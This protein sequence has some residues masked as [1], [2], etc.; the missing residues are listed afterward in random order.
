MTQKASLRQTKFGGKYP[1]LCANLESMCAARC[2]EI[3]NELLESDTDFQAITKQ[4]ANTSQIVMNA[5]N[6]H[7]K[8]ELFEAYSDA[9]YLGE[10]YELNAI[11][12]E[13]FFDAIEMAEQLGLLREV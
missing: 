7:G 5:L 10:V 12:K 2:D 3:T 13:A 4:R 11:Y 9:I 1:S 8:G 6:E